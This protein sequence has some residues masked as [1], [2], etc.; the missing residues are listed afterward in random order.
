[1]KKSTRTAVPRRAVLSLAAA[2]LLGACDDRAANQYRMTNIVPT[3][4]RGTNDRVRL[5]DDAEDEQTT[6]SSR[7][8]TTH[9][10]AGV[11]V[12]HN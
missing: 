10:R 6:S 12:H 1:M 4:S 8:V 3:K 2:S 7:R 5:I 11:T 9:P